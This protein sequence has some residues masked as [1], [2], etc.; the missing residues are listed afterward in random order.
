VERLEGEAV[1]AEGDGDLSFA[2]QEQHFAAV[3]LHGL[4][5]LF[6]RY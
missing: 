5:P 1:V 3:A 6:R 4:P 2:A